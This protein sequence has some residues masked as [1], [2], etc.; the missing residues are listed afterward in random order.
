MDPLKD[1]EKAFDYSDDIGFGF[2][3]NFGYTHQ[4]MQNESTTTDPG[5]GR[6]TV[7]KL[8]KGKV[9]EGTLVGTIYRGADFVQTFIVNSD[10]TVKLTE[11]G[12]PEIK[13][14]TAS[15]N[16]EDGQ[17]VL[18]WNKKPG[19]THLVVS[20]EYDMVFDSKPKAKPPVNFEK[21]TFEKFF[22][23]EEL[24]EIARTAGTVACWDFNCALGDT[25]KEKYESLYVKLHE[26]TN[27]LLKKGAAGYFWIAASPEVISIFETATAGFAPAPWD[28]GDIIGGVMPLGLPA[29]SYHGSVNLRWR[30]YSDS[31]MPTN[32]VLIGCND[33]REDK[34]HYARLIVANFII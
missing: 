17:I 23:S 4:F 27:L 1:L 18:H 3:L 28:R 25:I 20:Y 34:S 13:V 33:K 15:V 24:A 32:M 2:D 29:V 10:G 26:M 19:S 30:L 14:E 7:H 11:V 22:T 16:H 5:K 31:A 9:L 21:P 12:R 6:E 8:Q